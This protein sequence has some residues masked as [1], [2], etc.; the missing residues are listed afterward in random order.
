MKSV[1]ITIQI[2]DN[3]YIKKLD[4]IYI[5][6]NCSLWQCLKNFFSSDVPTLPIVCV[7]VARWLLTD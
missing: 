5:Y 2:P 4:N 6:I 3:V 1:C 7:C